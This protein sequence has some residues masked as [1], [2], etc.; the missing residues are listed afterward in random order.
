MKVGDLVK[1]NYAG[2]TG[3]S[4]GLGIIVEVEQYNNGPRCRMYGVKW[5][6]DY[7]KFFSP[8]EDLEVISEGR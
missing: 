6:G 2:L 8:P 7:G 1:K 4:A 3:S 5:Q